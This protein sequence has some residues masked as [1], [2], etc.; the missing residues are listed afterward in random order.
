MALAISAVTN[1]KDCGQEYRIE[2]T[3]GASGT[4]TTGGETVTW[5][6]A[7]IKTAK[8]PTFGMGFTT[9][10]WLAVYDVANNKVMLWNGTT[11]FSSGGSLTGI[12]VY[13]SLYFPK[14]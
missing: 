3:L 8:K 6:N 2:A 10:G 1:A 14:S 9:A 11:Q 12:T 13:M 5:K 7:K 4:Y